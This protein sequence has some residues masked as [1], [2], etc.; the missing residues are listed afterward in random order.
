MGRVVERTGKSARVELL[1]AV[2]SHRLEAYSVEQRALEALPRLTKRVLRVEG[3]ED[4][5]MVPVGHDELVTGKEVYAVIPTD[6]LGSE[7]LASAMTGLVRLIP[8]DPSSSSVELLQGSLQA[9]DHLLLLGLLQDSPLAVEIR[10]TP[11][12]PAAGAEARRDRLQQALQHELEDLSRVS[13]RSLPAT[14]SKAKLAQ[15]LGGI[16]DESL[17]LYVSSSPNSTRITMSTQLSRISNNDA[18]QGFEPQN[19]EALRRAILVQLAQLRADPCTAVFLAERA[20]RELRAG[21]EDEW[22]A[23]SG[24]LAQLYQTLWRSDWALEVLLQLRSLAPTLTPELGERAWLTIL[25]QSL[26]LGENT[27]AEDAL[28]AL[29]LLEEDGHRHQVRTLISIIDALEQLS[30]WRDADLWRERLRERI[31]KSDDEQHYWLA[32]SALYSAILRKKAIDEGILDD[33]L[34]AAERLGPLW[35][36]Q[37]NALASLDELRN[38]G[39]LSRQTLERVEDFDRLGAPAQAYRLLTESA[40]SVLAE[41]PIQAERLLEQAL[42]FAFAARQPLWAMALLS[43]IEDARFD[44]GEQA[45]TGELG[46]QALELFAGFDR[47]LQLGR[48]ALAAAQRAVD[49]VSAVALLELAR[50]LFASI[51]D[52]L[53]TAISELAL[54]RFFLRIQ[55]FDEA[56]RN[57]ERARPFEGLVRDPALSALRQKVEKELQQQQS[58]HQSAP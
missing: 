50:T 7:R 32:Y 41:N 42:A 48:R 36:A 54:A 30:R 8:R 29:L 38:E 14:L 35:R 11:L 27:L 44:R 21:D 49:G 15:E 34:T 22:I 20:L 5:W 47:R 26:S 25:Q 31:D 10:L 58:F 53:N 4:S 19:D 39:T 12:G 23:L 3:S 45:L 6:A 37:V 28:G 40:R 33:A 16:Q 56:R 13:V 18:L 55:S 1:S 9:D 52:P 2:D 51:G 46:A 43:A 17:L 57:I 24:T